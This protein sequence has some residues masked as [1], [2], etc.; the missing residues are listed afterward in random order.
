MY[1]EKRSQQQRTRDFTEICITL[2]WFRKAKTKT[3]FVQNLLNIVQV[4]IN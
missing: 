4:F 1:K 3:T 2:A